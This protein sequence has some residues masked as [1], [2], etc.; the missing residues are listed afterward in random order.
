MGVVYRAED[1]RL[2]R[3]RRARSSCRRR[4]PRDDRERCARFDARGPRRLGPQSSAHLH[5]LRH[6]RARRAARSSRWN[7]SKGRRSS[8][9][10]GGRSA[11][12]ETTVARPGDRDRRR[13]RRRAR[14]RA[15]S[16]ATSNPPTSSSRRRGHAKVLDFG[17]C[18]DDTPSGHRSDGHRRGH[19][20]Q[21][22]TADGARHGDRHA[23][24]HV[25]GAGARR[26]RST[27]AP[28]CSRSAAVLYEMLTGDPPFRGPDRCGADAMPSC[29]ATAAESDSAQPGG[30]ARVSTR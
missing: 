4:W 22:W 27:R 7:C 17:H 26:G 5:D 12:A 29:T 14:A 19:D 23:R 11:A 15:S 1:T 8:A 3:A 13:A 25:A 18:E 21:R 10:I 16:I 9:L 30:A 2:G 28:I 6:R 24:L 20:D